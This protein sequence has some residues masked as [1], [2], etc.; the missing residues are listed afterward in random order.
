M[1]NPKKKYRSLMDYLI[2]NI[3]Q[4]KVGHQKKRLNWN[5]D[6]ISP[7]VLVCHHYL[8]WILHENGYN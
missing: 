6:Q 7:A 3:L 1:C 8:Q 5:N 2:S 4:I